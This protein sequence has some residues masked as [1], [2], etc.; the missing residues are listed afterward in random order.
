VHILPDVLSGVMTLVKVVLHE[1]LLLP[2]HS[3]LAFAK[4][5]DKF[6]QVFLVSNFSQGVTICGVPGSV[7]YF[8]LILLVDVKIVKVNWAIFCDSWNISSETPL[9]HLLGR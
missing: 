2:E 4:L 1:V 8:P 9:F 7:L 6:E 5:A 3:L